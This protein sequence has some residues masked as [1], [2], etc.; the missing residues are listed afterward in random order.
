MR[1]KIDKKFNVNKAA[2]IIYLVNISQIILFLGLIFY[3]YLFREEAKLLISDNLVVLFAILCIVFFMNVYITLRDVSS[4]KTL[5][6]QNL[7]QKEML[8]QIED[9][10]NT[11]RGQRHDFLNHLQ[12]V[13]S[14]IEMNEYIEARDYIEKIY[15][16]IKKVN[17][18]IKTSKAAINALLQAKQIDCE[19]RGIVVKLQVSTRLENLKI[20]SWEMC[21]VLSNIIDNAMDATEDM[22]KRFIEIEILEDTE[23]YKFVVKNNGKM[24]AEDI[25]EKIFNPGFTTKNEGGQGM[26][27][28]ISKGIIERYGGD[29]LV[30]SNE[31]ITVFYVNI[32]FE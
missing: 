14:L 3:S 24:I 10:N 1:R 18:V 6:E 5:H 25:C 31:N 16:D 27:L 2:V 12:V 17:R 26:G 8:S 28:Y 29:I 7:I 21:R 15:E 32:P 19:D 22:E 13:F 11:M 4:L 9:L 20:P 30:E 23:N